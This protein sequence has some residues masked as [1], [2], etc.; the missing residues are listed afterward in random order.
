MI[1]KLGIFSWYGYRTAIKRRLQMIRKAGFD[2]TMLWWGDEKA[3][4]ELEKTELVK[5]TRNQGLEI[6]NIHA[7][8]ANANAIWSADIE[9]RRQQIEEYKAYISDCGRYQ[10]PIMVMHI[11]RG[12]E[13]KEANEFGKSAI[14]ELCSIAEENSVRVALENTRN[15]SL[16]EY[17]LDN[18][19]EENLGLCYDTSHAQ[20]YGDAD[21][22]LMEKYT[23]R[24]FCFH[25]SDNDGQSDKHWITGEG[26]IDWKEFRNKFPANY[27]G[28]VSAEVYPKETGMNEADFLAA[29]HAALK[30]IVEG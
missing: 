8:F 15:N 7:P 4:D 9:V 22:Q 26:I 28:T 23:E 11:S 29:A 20:L 1:R 14:E 18:I 13:I 12:N 3:F 19:Q 5:E 2:S 17:L 21:F 6:E 10:I 27:E 25:L 24:V 30:D 16:L